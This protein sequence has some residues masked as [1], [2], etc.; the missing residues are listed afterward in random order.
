M[1]VVLVVEDDAEIRATLRMALEDEGYT[2]LE[3]QNGEAAI[4]ALHSNKM[5]M[6]V[7]LDLLLPL[8]SGAAILDMVATD[9]D[10]ATRNAYILLTAAHQSFHPPFTH[11]LQQLQVPIVHKPFDLDTLFEVVTQGA[12]RIGA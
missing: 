1:S 9:A 2:V 10:L 6:V 4:A 12:E 5:P 7:L 11:V 3:A 8:Y